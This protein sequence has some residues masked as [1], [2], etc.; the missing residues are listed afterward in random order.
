MSKIQIIYDLLNG[1]LPNKVFYGTNRVDETDEVYPFIVYQEVSNRAVTYADNVTFVRIITLQI[2]LVTER[3][4]P[5]MEELLEEALML[6][7]FNYQMVTEYF[8]EDSSINRVY[9]IKME[10]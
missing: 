6:S 4:E 10:D 1:V 9:E 2:T 3:K 8:N 5:T 7:G